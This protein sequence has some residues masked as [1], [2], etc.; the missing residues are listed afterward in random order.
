[1]LVA[2]LSQALMVKYSSATFTILCMVIVVPLS[3][4]VFALPSIMGARAEK[5]P[6]AT[7]YAIALVFVGIVVF[8]FGDKKVADPEQGQGLME[9]L[10]TPQISFQTHDSEPMAQGPS[11]T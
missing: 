9:A 10:L 6:G 8:R 3:S 11:M 4:L 5:L 7:P 1:M 2:Q